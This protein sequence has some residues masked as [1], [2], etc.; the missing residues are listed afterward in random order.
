MLLCYCNII[1]EILLLASLFI[2]EQLSKR[3]SMENSSDAN[4]SD[5]DKKMKNSFE[6]SE[7]TKEKKDTKKSNKKT[8]S[9][10]KLISGE[11]QENKPEK[12]NKSGDEEFSLIN[13]IMQKNQKESKDIDNPENDTKEDL[14]IE[15][16]EGSNA[17][18]TSENSEEL[19]GDEKA[20]LANEYIDVS[21]SQVETELR[22]SEPD[23]KQEAES[24]ASKQYLERLKNS[25]S[26]EEEVNDEL[27]VKVAD[28]VIEE[29]TTGSLEQNKNYINE[30]E[31]PIEDLN[32]E[33]LEPEISIRDEQNSEINEP[34][35]T[36]NV[37]DNILNQ[38]SRIENQ[39]NE[40]RLP[41]QSSEQLEIS[42]NRRRAGD[43]LI[44]GIIGYVIGKRRGEKL[45][46]RKLNPVKEKLE[47]QVVDLQ[48][49]ITEQEIRVRNL[50]SE[51]YEQ[52]VSFVSKVKAIESD[53]KQAEDN[54]NKQES[55]VNKETPDI[56]EKKVNV[57][58]SLNPKAVEI[59]SLPI[60]LEMSEDIK[61]DN[62]SLRY[63]F[64]SGNI[65]QKQLRE[66]IKKYLSGERID[67]Q[68]PVNYEVENQENFEKLTSGKSTQSKNGAV[69]QN[70]N[71][72]AQN[73]TNNQDFLST[74][75]GQSN[76][77]ENSEKDIQQSSIKTKNTILLTIV[78]AVAVAIILIL[79]FT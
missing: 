37:T 35:N 46:E 49:K 45:T 41:M 1:Q 47:K 25:I 57:E 58:K 34:V 28:R 63:L 9:L 54:I 38:T 71:I 43:F 21:L 70:N 17:E 23:S 53:S 32:N 7:D 8:P 77:I 59:L 74:D 65:D 13:M 40:A 29:N 27:P 31:V 75:E 18:I 15:S 12:N 69:N 16:S 2:E 67:N 14:A 44:G 22:N 20:D 11:N 36:G 6:S 73:N 33:V 56:T 64:E 30:P 51:N 52:K 39:P 68:I 10:F 3:Y 62:K 61:I 76:S 55:V 42:I 4:S 79:S 50:A 60:L 5:K 72:Q 66:I 48:N 78:L 26:I 19:T 24:N